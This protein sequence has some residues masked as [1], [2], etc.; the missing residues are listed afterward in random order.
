MILCLECLPVFVILVQAGFCLPLQGQMEIFNASQ[1]PNLPP[2]NPPSTPVPAV[3]PRTGNI[4]AAAG[5]G[6]CVVYAPLF[7]GGRPPGRPPGGNGTSS[8]NSSSSSN[9]PLGGPGPPLNPGEPEGGPGG[10]GGRP[11]DGP[12]PI[13][14]PWPIP[15]PPGMRSSSTLDAG[16]WV[17]AGRSVLGPEAP[18]P[19]NG[20]GIFQHTAGLCR[21]PAILLD[22][23]EI[24]VPLMNAPPAAAAA[25]GNGNAPPP[26]ARPIVAG[27]YTVSFKDSAWVECPA[28]VT[29]CSLSNQ[30][31]SLG[32]P[33]SPASLVSRVAQVAPCLA[34]AYALLNPDNDPAAVAAAREELAARGAVAAGAAGGGDTGGSEAYGVSVVLPAVLGSIGR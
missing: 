23:M 21:K 29:S 5:R 26:G 19:P 1:K 2:Q 9:V 8:N 3:Q 17:I 15:E 34:A 6:W 28:P 10:P 16:N 27:S 25:G 4:S 11:P 33:G 7:P 18:Q 32:P 31:Q 30:S 13:G 12:P 20:T 14:P 24:A 22:N